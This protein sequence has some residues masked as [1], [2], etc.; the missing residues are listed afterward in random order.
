MRGSPYECSVI[1]WLLNAHAAAA[2][3][4]RFDGGYT[5]PEVVRLEALPVGEEAVR[6]AVEG[7]SVLTARH[8]APYTATQHR[9]TSCSQDPPRFT[10]GFP[11][12]ARDFVVGALICLLPGAGCAEVDCKRGSCTNPVRSNNKDCHAYR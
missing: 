1:F 11:G 9:R 7:A 4:W 3:G 12:P 5:W 6:A 10:R 2:T 8:L